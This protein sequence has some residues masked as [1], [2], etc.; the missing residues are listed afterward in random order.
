[1]NSV[2]LFFLVLLLQDGFAK[3]IG[4]FW[5]VTDF[6]YDVNYSSTGDPNNMC[7]QDDVTFNATG[8]YGNYLC[9][10]PWQLIS[11]AIEAMYKIKPDPDFIIWTGDSV[12]HV[13]ESDLDLDKVYTLI[14]NITDEII[15]VFPNTSLF[16]VLG[17]H[18]PF[19]SNQMPYDVENNRYYKDILNVS[20]WNIVL[21]ANESKQFQ[22]GGYYSSQI[23]KK[24]RLIGLNTNLYYDQDKLTRDLDDPANQFAWLK[25]ELEGARKRQEAVYII[26]HVP[27]GSFELGTG[28]GWFYDKYNRRY[29]DLLEEYSDV[30]MAQMYGHEH[31]DSFRVQ[32]DAEGK[33][34]NT[35]FLC[36]AVTPWKS[37]LPG[38]GANNPSVRLY[39]YDRDT[40]IPQSYTQYYLNLTRANLKGNADNWEKEYD[41]SDVYAIDQLTPTALHGLARGFGDKSNKVFLSYLEFNSVMWDT[42]HEC[43]DTCFIHH[44]CA[45]TQLDYG[46]FNACLA[47]DG[48][49][50][51]ISPTDTTRHHSRRPTVPAQV[52]SYLY[53]VMGGLAVLLFVLFLVVAVMCF[54]R[55]NFRSFRV[56]KYSKFG[57]LSVNS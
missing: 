38:V 41:T 20:N 54:R 32:L 17:N 22:H 11:S 34:I 2:L 31:T 42:S 23:S 40:A 6:H 29:L 53:Y 43:N 28:L 19:P 35:L 50:T 57:S 26:A 36:P 12:P 1:M 37:S 45:I 48:R 49:L 13:P 10:S 39:K 5:Q 3:D 14:G 18:D 44:Y 15:R 51:T 56:P 47:G 9:D 8:S 21:R 27:P 16:P 24:F 25:D 46:Q 55:G 4:V 7:H 30:I 33:P 52:P